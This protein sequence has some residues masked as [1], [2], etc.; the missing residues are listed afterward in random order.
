MPGRQEHAIAS[1]PSPPLANSCRIIM[2]PS[3]N[4]AIPQNSLYPKP[5]L[6]IDVYSVINLPPHL[7]HR[8]G[9]A[10][11]SGVRFG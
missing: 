1:R 3:G 6:G 9:H 4:F 2:K 10:L 5:Y 8:Q 7:L 11:F